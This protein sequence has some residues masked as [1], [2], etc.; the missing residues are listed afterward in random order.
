MHFEAG[1]GGGVDIMPDVMAGS[2][3][4]TR[5]SGDMNPP[6]CGCCCGGSVS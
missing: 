4:V 6:S 3:V 1:G 5:G 2:V